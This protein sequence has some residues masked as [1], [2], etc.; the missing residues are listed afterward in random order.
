MKSFDELFKKI[1]FNIDNNDNKNSNNKNNKR[2]RKKKN[3]KNKV[4]YLY[5]LF[6]GLIRELIFTL[7][8]VKSLIS[9]SSTSK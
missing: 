5:D 4:N 7:L 2:H 9:L 6:D 8:D 1:S 3:K